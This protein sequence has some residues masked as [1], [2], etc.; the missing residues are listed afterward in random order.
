MGAGHDHYA[1]IAQNPPGRV[2]LAG[3]G[4]ER[5]S[6]LDMNFGTTNGTAIQARFRAG[7]T[8]FAHTLMDSDSNWGL[9]S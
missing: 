6:G 1:V 3:T 4:R 2:I 7:L 5:F 9:V 8:N